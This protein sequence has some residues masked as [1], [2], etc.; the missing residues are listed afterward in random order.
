MRI[1]RH[2]FFSEPSIKELIPHKVTNRRSWS[3]E[4]WELFLNSIAMQLFC[5][6]EFCL[7]FYKIN[8][9]T[10][11]YAF[12]T[13]SWSLLWLTILPFISANGFHSFK[14]LSDEIVEITQK[15]ALWLI[16]LTKFSNLILMPRL[17]HGLLN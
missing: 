9:E 7:C 17:V 14:R 15:K 2:E 3:Y 6:H 16:W 10:R 1:R 12:L 5:N 8:I 13:Y 4:L 11:S